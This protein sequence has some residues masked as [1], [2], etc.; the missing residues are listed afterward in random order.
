[1]IMGFL[2]MVMVEGTAAMTDDMYF[3]DINR[4]NYFAHKVQTGSFNKDSNYSYTYGNRDIKAYCLPK[5]VKENTK[6]WD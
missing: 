2:L 4:C 1:M 6:F 3:K 5:M